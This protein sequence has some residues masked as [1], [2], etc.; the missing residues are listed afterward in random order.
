MRTLD[1]FFHV[2]VPQFSSFHLVKEVNVF[3]QELEL[4]CLFTAG[5]SL[6][7][8][9][10]PTFFLVPSAFICYKKTLTATKKTTLPADLF[11]ECIGGIVGTEMQRCGFLSL[12][13]PTLP[14][15]NAQAGQG[16]LPYNI[17]GAIM[18]AMDDVC[19]DPK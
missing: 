9:F 13:G 14:P 19:S 10:V 1:I 12:T 16:N 3:P 18:V 11:Q 15:F 8:G 6:F 4:C 17:G 2:V 5:S 7:L